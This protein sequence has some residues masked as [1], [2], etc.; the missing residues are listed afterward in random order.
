MPKPQEKKS[1][2]KSGGKAQ[3]IIAIIKEEAMEKKRAI[4]SMAASKIREIEEQSV[5]RA[6]Y[7]VEEIVRDA[8]RQRELMEN[9]TRAEADLYARR[10]M[11]RA[12]EDVFADILNRTKKLLARE[13]ESG[14]QAYSEF[15]KRAVSEAQKL[16]NGGA[17]H[18]MPGDPSIPVIKAA[19]FSVTESLPSDRLGGAVFFSPDGERRVD[20]SLLHVLERDMGELRCMVMDSLFQGKAI[21]A[22]T[23]DAERETA[24]G[25]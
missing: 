12:R 23:T 4:E 21:G 16:F 17:A 10:S 18:V 6:S 3:G 24:R 25:D 5:Q 2:V 7:A 22:Q 1:E 14:T 20:S 15:M 19:G 9:R 11:A 13:R 8:A